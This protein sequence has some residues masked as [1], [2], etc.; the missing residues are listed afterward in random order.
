MPVP[1]VALLIETSNAY[2][3]GLLEGI[4]QYVQEHSPWS[5]YLPERGRGD[6][7]HRSLH[8]WKGD[9]MIVRVENRQMA[10]ALT[11]WRVP[12][13]DLSASEMLP[14]VPAVHS[15]VR[16]E[17]E[18]AFAHLWERG[19]RH[20]G[21]CGVSTY[22]WAVWQFERFSQLAAESNCQLASHVHPLPSHGPGDWTKQRKSLAAWLRK[23]P[24][25]IGIFTCYDVL[26]QQVLDAC[27]GLGLR[28]PDDVAVVGV[29]NDPVRC[30]LSDPPLSSVVP[31]TR[32]VGYLAAELLDDL[33]NGKRVA[34]GLRLCPPIGVVTRRS[35]DSLA[36]D[37]PDLTT[38]VR[39][40]RDNACKPIGVKHLL[41][42]VPLSRRALEGR[43]LK[44]LGRT[45]HQEIIRCRI[46]KAKQLFTDTDL[47]V[48]AIA[49]RVGLSNAEYLSVLFK[50]MVGVSPTAY[51]AEAKRKG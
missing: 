35:T 29:D 34:S 31:D 4:A 46:E 45:P 10:L 14:N 50:K 15:D 21:F 16:A 48:K 42:E 30:S 36:I 23:L 49:R 24:K 40:I 18:L 33:M 6:S 28:V 32:G 25:P 38:A 9:G 17:A 41:A 7:L 43:F 12:I 13:V 1:R 47:P 26:G 11:E 19:F 39:F 2:A 51:R 3:R 20:M 22:T 44:L 37:D 5:V 27:K 8:G